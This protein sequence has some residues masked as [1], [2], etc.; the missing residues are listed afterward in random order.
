[1]L[2]YKSDYICGDHH[3]KI[4]GENTNANNTGGVVF[5]AFF[6]QKNEAGKKADHRDKAYDGGDDR[7]CLFCFIAYFFIGCERGCQTQKRLSENFD[8]KFCNDQTEAP[9]L[10]AYRAEDETEAADIVVF[11]KN[12]ILVFRI[13]G[14]EAVAPEFF[15]VAFAVV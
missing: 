11:F 14:A 6:I 15:N 5:S 7:H 3:N 1:M 9:L 2:F 13:D 12:Y 4:Y 10:L 8:E